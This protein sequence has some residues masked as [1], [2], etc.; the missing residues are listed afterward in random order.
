MCRPTWTTS[1]SFPAVRLNRN[2]QANTDIKE[3]SPQTGEDTRCWI[4]V[5]QKKSILLCYQIKILPVEQLRIP[6]GRPKFPFLRKWKF[7]H[8]IRLQI[9]CSQQ[10]TSRK[11]FDR[12]T[13]QTCVFGSNLRIKVYNTA[14]PDRL[15]AS[16]HSTA[17]VGRCVQV[18]W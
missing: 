18:V 7:N 8:P 17:R 13:E 14:R 15:L 11:I 1:S 16:C 12:N 6:R 2:D 5:K 10:L 3:A 9:V 4:L